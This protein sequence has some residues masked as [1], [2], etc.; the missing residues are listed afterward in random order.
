MQNVAMWYYTTDRLYVSN[1]R[2]SQ[3]DNTGIMKINAIHQAHGVQRIEFTEPAIKTQSAKRISPV[4]DTFEHFSTRNTASSAAYFTGKLL[5]EESMNEEQTYMKKVMFDPRSYFSSV[6]LQ[7]GRVELDSDF[8]E[9]SSL[10]KN[11]D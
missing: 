5:T 10:K 6:R 2:E 1:L 3:A 11:D 7:Q 8:N 4:R 9:D